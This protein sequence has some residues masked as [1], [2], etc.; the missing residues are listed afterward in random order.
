MY[1]TDDSGNSPFPADLLI[2]LVAEPSGLRGDAAGGLPDAE[3][4]VVWIVW[5]L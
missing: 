1:G 2:D 4:V 3:W 5:W